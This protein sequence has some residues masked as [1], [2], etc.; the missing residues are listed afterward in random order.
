MGEDPWEE[1]RKVPVLTA[2]GRGEYCGLNAERLRSTSSTMANSS[3][4]CKAFLDWFQENGGTIDTNSISLIDFPAS[5]GGRGAVALQDI[6][7][8]HVSS[9]YGSYV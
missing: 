1:T 7:V 9:T 2:S 8:S 3:T 4:V 6:A 5:E